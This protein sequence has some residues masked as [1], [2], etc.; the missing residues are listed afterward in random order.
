MK[1]KTH[2]TI[3]IASMVTLCILISCTNL[4]EKVYSEL[5][6]DNFYKSE[7]EIVAAL[8]P[9]YGGLRD[10]ESTLEAASLASDETLIPTRG[11]DWYDGGIYL[12]LHEHNWQAQLSYFGNIWNYGYGRVNKANQLI[13]Q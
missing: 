12:R 5:L 11:K 2:S 1:M 9:A 8:A 6:K 7:A 10:I 3:R 4:D 13:Y